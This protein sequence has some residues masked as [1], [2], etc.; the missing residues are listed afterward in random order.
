MHFIQRFTENKVGRDFVVGDLHGHYDEL[1]A[2]LDS[3]DF[4]FQHDRLFTVGDLCDRG[5]KSE[6]VIEL[7]NEPWF[8]SVRGNHDQFILD[9]YESERVMITRGYDEHSPDE[10]HFRVTGFE[11]IWFFEL[12]KQR[13]RELGELLMVLPYVIE[14]EYK[15]K[16]IGITHAGVPVGF[17][18]WTDFVNDID[19]RSTRELTLRHRRHAQHASR[20]KSK[21]IEGINYTVHGHSCFIEPVFSQ[22]SCFIDTFDKSEGLT[23]LSLE[24]VV[25]SFKGLLD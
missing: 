25:E 7:T 9:R 12:E 22:N 1:I 10:N 19:S 5:P 23:V 15:C 24:D 18:S 2:E 16:L 4:D 11:S 14:V 17:E 20:K 21:W 8:F 13:Q 6:E 3:L